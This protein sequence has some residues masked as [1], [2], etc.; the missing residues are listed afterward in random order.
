VLFEYYQKVPQKQQP[1]TL[2]ELEP[3]YRAVVHGCLAGEYQ[4]ALDAVY[5]DRIR[6]G[7]EGYSLHKLGA[8]SQGLTALAAFFPDGW[9]QPVQ[10]DLSEADQAWLLAEASF[11]LMSLGRLSEAAESGKA[12]LKIKVKR[13]DWKNAARTARNLADLQLPLGRLEEAATAAQHSLDYATRSKDLFQ[14]IGSHAT[15]ATVYHRQGQMM[16]AQQAFVVAEQLQQQRQPE[17]PQLYTLQGFYYCVWLLDQPHVDLSQILA[18]G[19]TILEVQKEVDWSSKLDFA[20][21]YLILAR[22][23]CQLRDTTQATDYFEK[24][25]SGIRKAG[26]IEFIPIFL[27]DRANFYLD[28]Q[29]FDEGLRDLDEA[30][31][32]IERSDMKLY[33]VDYHLAMSRYAR[34]QQPEKVQFHENEAKKLIEATGY[35]LR[36]V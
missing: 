11:C 8:Y 13:E 16:Q 17:Y 23:Y 6:R 18:R 29:R 5:Q 25:V 24:A 26:K 10:Q 36:K 19:K 4:T 14:Q 30:R 7:N 31:Q 2:E 9:L 21:S 35:H 12:D 15:I 3:L 27:I 34:V 1:D 28:Q 33:A 20:L 22:T 32:I